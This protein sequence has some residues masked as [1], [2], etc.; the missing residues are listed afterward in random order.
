[1][2]SSFKQKPV[3]L[4]SSNI[5]KNLRAPFSVGD[6][7]KSHYNTASKDSYLLVA[8]LPKSH[9]S[10]RLLVKAKLAPL[11]RKPVKKQWLQKTAAFREPVPGVMNLEAVKTLTR[12]Q[13]MLTTVS[14]PTPGSVLASITMTP[15]VLTATGTK[16]TESKIDGQTPKQ[17]D[18][19]PT[20]AD[21]PLQSD[22]EQEEDTSPTLS[23]TRDPP[24]T[25]ALG[26]PFV[27]SKTRQTQ[28]SDHFSNTRKP[29]ILSASKSQLHVM[30]VTST[31]TY[32]Q[33]T[34][35]AQNNSQVGLT[36]R[37]RNRVDS[38]QMTTDNHYESLI[39]R[40]EY[41]PETKQA[42][43]IFSL[44]D[45][46]S[47]P[48]VGENDTEDARNK[49]TKEVWEPPLNKAKSYKESEA[50]RQVAAI[51]TEKQPLLQ[52]QISGVVPTTATRPT[53]GLL[54]SP[55]VLTPY[56]STSSLHT[57]PGDEGFQ[58]PE[59]SPG[60]ARWDSQV[61]METTHLEPVQA[62]TEAADVTQASPQRLANQQSHTQSTSSANVQIALAA[63][64]DSLEG[65]MKAP[66]TFDPEHG[67]EESLLP[68]TDVVTESLLGSLQ[69]SQTLPISSFAS[70]T[71]GAYSLA[72]YS[73][74]ETPSIAPSLYPQELEAFS[75]ARPSELPIRK[76]R[77]VCPYPPLPAHGTFYFRTIQKPA[78]LQYKHYIQYACYP[79]Y[80]LANG[81]VY[82]YCQ[83]NGTWSGI[84]PACLGKMHFHHY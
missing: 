48:P 22:H 15:P 35:D 83:Q 30:S 74:G 79:G 38:V 23:A 60:R 55:S 53:P 45:H 59:V 62:V 24:E 39:D 16:L 1:M 8:S 36:G 70:Q 41:P 49:D 75:E 18:T 58:G 21:V 64:P 11:Q 9:L 68:E 51:S 37:V 19:G 10:E 34:V 56:S 71:N 40:P 44:D 47:V 52:E 77:P 27:G 29:V 32:A 17:T 14:V 82:S 33:T 69:R 78:R 76:Q 4:S 81:D 46:P 80:T 84:T 63:E 26:L 3:V 12:A 28:E 50:I 42:P 54:P 25:H 7:L 2:M 31:S 20:T 57:D 65:S 72:F 73:T 6:D 13:Q 61:L 66:S 43:L 67:L 5:E